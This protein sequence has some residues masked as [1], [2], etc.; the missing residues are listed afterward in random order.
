M[1]ARKKLIHFLRAD[2]AAAVSPAASSSTSALSSPRSFSSNDSSSVSDDDS[3]SSSSSSSSFPPSASSSP[4]RYSISPPPKSPWS[5]TAHLLP[6]LGV[7]DASASSSAA[8]T[9]LIASL[10]KERG[11]VYSLA[12][13][14]DLL[15]T[16]TDSDTVRVWRDRRELAALRAGSGLVKAIVVSASDGRVFTGHQD[17]KV[18]VWRRDPASAGAAAHH[19][20][21]GSLPALGDYL[22]SSVN[23]SSYVAASKGRRRR[24]AVWLRH[25]DAVSSLSLD[26]DAG[27]LYSGSWDRTFK[28]WRVADSRC[29]DSVAAAH[30]DAVN[31]VAAAGFGGLVLTGSADGAVKVWRRE[32]V[33]A[34]GG[35]AERTRHVLE[36]VLR[37]GGGGGGGDGVAV[38]AVAACPEARAVYVGTS[39]GLVTCWRWSGGHGEGAGGEP[40][41][42]AVLAGG[43]RTG[44]VMCLAVSGRVVVSGSADRT[45]C[46]WRRYGDGQRHVRLAVL[47]GH[48]GPV[49]CVAV[50]PDDAVDDDGGGERRFVV[51]SGSLDGSVKVWRLSED[52][53]L[54]PPAV[55]EA[56]VPSMPVLLESEAWT[57]LPSPPAAA[58]PELIKRVAAA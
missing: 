31:T 46:V 15:Y 45:L 3:I 38:T 30:D 28:A 47:E 52:R 32:T 17:G 16:G 12:A 2:P 35:G 18:R 44:G 51:Y 36:R 53:P 58:P 50:A 13:A 37:E 41:R 19:R 7:G 10:V 42:A 33:A 9:G 11:K 21:V 34:A 43:H 55:T 25:T 14:G 24:R 48:T 26:E 4:S 49:K 40:W 6:G 8:D 1:A 27:I 23:P 22:A 29:L 56:A 54:E 20:R 5:A 57:A 39:D